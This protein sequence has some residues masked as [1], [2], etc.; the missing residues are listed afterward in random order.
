MKSHTV[1]LPPVAICEMPNGKLLVYIEKECL[2]NLL[3]LNED[4]GNAL[5]LCL[6]RALQAAKA[7]ETANLSPR[8]RAALERP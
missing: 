5:G 8:E 2:G 4:F 7:S 6:V 3:D 1:N